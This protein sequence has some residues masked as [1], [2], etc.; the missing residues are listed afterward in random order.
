M[1][2]EQTHQRGLQKSKKRK[3]PQTKKAK[4]AEASEDKDTGVDTN[5]QRGV[6]YI[7]ALPRK[8]AESLL[9]KKRKRSG[10]KTIFCKN[11][12][13][14]LSR[15]NIAPWW[16][17]SCPK[18]CDYPVLG[19]PF[20]EKAGSLCREHCRPL[21]VEVKCLSTKAMIQI[22]ESGELEILGNN[23]HLV[24]VHD[25]EEGNEVN[26][27]IKTIS[28]SM[29]CISK[30]ISICDL[31]GVVLVRFRLDIYPK[32]SAS[33][34]ETCMTPYENKNDGYLSTL[35]KKKPTTVTPSPK[36][37]LRANKCR[38]DDESTFS[39]P[40]QECAFREDHLPEEF[41]AAI[42]RYRQVKS[43]GKSPRSLHFPKETKEDIH[44]SDC[45]DDNEESLND[46]NSPSQQLP[47]AA[48]KMS[49]PRHRNR[50]SLKPTAT[51]INRTRIA[52]EYKVTIQDKY[53]S[54]STSEGDYLRSTSN[55]SP[56]RRSLFGS[57]NKRS[58]PSAQNGR[59]KASIAEDKT[60]QNQFPSQIAA[61]KQTGPEKTM[62]LSVLT[63]DDDS[64]EDGQDVF[65][66]PPKQG[67]KSQSA[68]KDSEKDGKKNSEKATQDSN[69]EEV[70]QLLLA[71]KQKPGCPNT[72]PNTCNVRPKTKEQK[73]DD[74]T[75]APKPTGAAEDEARN[76]DFTT[77]DT[78]VAADC[79][80]QRAIELLA[81]P[82]SQKQTYNETQSAHIAREDR[83]QSTSATEKA[84]VGS[85][86]SPSHDKLGEKCNNNATPQ[87]SSSA[88]ESEQPLF[89]S[90]GPI[91]L[92][93]SPVECDSSQHENNIL[94]SLDERTTAPLSQQ[95]FSLHCQQ[96]SQDIESSCKSKFTDHLE[97]PSGENQ[98]LSSAKHTSAVA[99]SSTPDETICQVKQQ[100]QHTQ[101]D[102]KSQI[103]KGSPRQQEKRRLTRPHLSF[104]G[105]NLSSSEA[106]DGE[107]ETYSEDRYPEQAFATTQ[108]S[109]A[110]AH[111][112]S[113]L[114]S[115]PSYNE[116]LKSQHDS[117]DED[118]EESNAEESSVLSMP[119]GNKLLSCTQA[120]FVILGTSQQKDTQNVIY[121]N[122]SVKSIR[123]LEYWQERLKEPETLQSKSSRA[124]AKLIIEKNI[125]VSSSS[126]FWLPG[127]VDDM[128]SFSCS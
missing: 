45:C 22:H 93:K 70:I 124:L 116:K 16:W 117:N 40:S 68:E 20:G 91:A 47:T 35:R 98:S 41:A 4:G 114:A 128:V 61:A 85:H 21:G 55:S 69:R 1:S 73:P 115:Q 119:L 12:P 60:R 30:I 51:T 39:Y 19:R 23:S 82:P 110:S 120:S 33:K 127:L 7:T 94:S 62:T 96:D 74:T 88:R 14:S 15:K 80:H 87:E 46:E 8:E 112:D 113:Q 65:A 95:E 105:M 52:K 125:G 122:N 109:T 90:Q 25:P 100:Q 66:D 71:M 84:T 101:K 48:S 126:P 99:S 54:Q 89:Q 50:S 67:W 17:Q 6:V 56:A 102:T 123:T 2:M 13:L 72:T 121:N 58:R 26:E 10:E 18:G 106:K 9:G 86:L 108:A 43:K 76:K 83:L 59:K 57:S 28:E 107:E 64:F 3:L 118:S 27:K 5:A 75:I 78:K 103:T 53:D 111:S 77:K 92:I 34:K 31:D 24:H 38:E 97:Y 63:G 44:M 81:S 11:L 49:T 37:E 79:G 36:K 42:I 104:Q 29:D 32:I